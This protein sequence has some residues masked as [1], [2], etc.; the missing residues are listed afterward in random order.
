MRELPTLDQL[1]NNIQLADQIIA[2]D[3]DSMSDPASD[4][5]FYQERIKNTQDHRAYLLSQLE[6]GNYVS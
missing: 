2:E 1:R 3:I 4:Q 5:K 6:A